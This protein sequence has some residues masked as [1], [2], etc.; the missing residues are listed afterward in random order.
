RRAF[1]PFFRIKSVSALLP[2][3]PFRARLPSGIALSTT[4]ESSKAPF[5]LR[6]ISAT[7]TSRRARAE[8]LVSPTKTAR[9]PVGLM[10]VDQ[11]LN[12]PT[13]VSMKAPA[14][15]EILE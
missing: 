2:A 8:L 15:G 4:S 10:I 1:F 9:T 12:A 13:I 14:N 3:Q 5:D 6:A 11:L 7:I